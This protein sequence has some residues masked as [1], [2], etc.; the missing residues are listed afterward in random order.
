MIN[1]CITQ[2]KIGAMGVVCPARNRALTGS[3]SHTDGP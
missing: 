2:H 1:L 3:P